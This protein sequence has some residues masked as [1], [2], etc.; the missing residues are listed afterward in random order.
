MAQPSAIR[1]GLGGALVG[2][3]AMASLSVAV[4]CGRVLQEPAETRVE[5]SDTVT[6]VGGGSAVP[7]LPFITD[8]SVVGLPGG[9][10]VPLGGVASPALIGDGAPLAVS[11]PDG[12]FI[13]YNAWSD[14]VP[15]E[16]EKS[17]SDQGI[18]PD[19]PV[20]IPSIRVLDLATGEDTPFAE[21]AYS[22]AW[23]ADGAI[24]YVQ[25]VEREFRA[26]GRYLGQVMVRASQDASPEAWTIEADRYVVYGWTGKTL[27]VERWKHEGEDV[28]ALDAPGRVREIASDANI[29]G[30][31]PDGAAV[32]VAEQG[33][34]VEIRLIDAASGVPTTSLALAAVVDLDGDPFGVGHGV[35]V[36]DRVVAP[37]ATLPYESHLLT[38]SVGEGN[39]LKV[40]DVGT[41]SSDAFPWGVKE[42]QVLEG[43]RV[44][45]W[46]PLPGTGGEAADRVYVSLDCDL[47]AGGCV[48]GPPVTDRIFRPIF[49]PSRPMPEV[50]LGG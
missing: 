49:N 20:G 27:L 37:L 29:V 47:I 25:G 15:V 7:P 31:A 50:T 14:L 2:S 18:G 9:R 30:I 44:V 24:A 43:W 38:I 35:W 46:S 21:G 17:W 4:S 42:P 28:L 1:W 16:P 32:L 19:D 41:F 6:V 40:A 26:A 8:D 12:R 11:S 3:I 39:R 33:P 48:Q 5:G 13:A 36:A 34:G 10:E 45:L 22:V 23:G